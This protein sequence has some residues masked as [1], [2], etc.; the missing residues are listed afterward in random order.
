MTHTTRATPSIIQ[1]NHCGRKRRPSRRRTTP[2]RRG[3]RSTRSRPRSGWRPAR[4]SGP[5]RPRPAS[6]PTASARQAG[7]AAGR[8]VS[9]PAGRSARGPGQPDVEGRLE[10]RPEASFEERREV[11]VGVGLRGRPGDERRDVD[12]DLARRDRSVA[13]ALG[14]RCRRRRVAV[15][16]HAA[17]A[18]RLVGAPRGQ[19]GRERQQDRG[20][21]LDAL[22]LPGI[23]CRVREPAVLVVGGGSGATTTSSEAEVSSA[24]YDPGVLPAAPSS[25]RLR[26]TST[27]APA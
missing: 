16:L 20:D 15:R 11:R 14:A 3:P 7:T 2:T 24:T 22:V 12:L 27:T 10:L 23:P 13:H 6:R 25:L 18:R 19:H 1:R 9:R 17:P 21:D 26:R 8:T 5:P 4:R